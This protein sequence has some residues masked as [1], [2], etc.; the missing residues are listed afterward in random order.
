MSSQYP[1]ILENEIIGCN[2]YC[3]SEIKITEHQLSSKGEMKTS[4][5]CDIF[6]LS[7]K[8]LKNPHDRQF[9]KGRKGKKKTMEKKGNLKK[10]KKLVTQSL[11]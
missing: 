3:Y 1:F 2:K 7:A 11:S 8:T 9:F 5:F 6:H 10:R 4:Q